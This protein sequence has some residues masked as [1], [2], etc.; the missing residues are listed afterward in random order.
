MQAVVDSIKK[1]IKDNIGRRV[2][3]T[4]KEGRNRFVVCRGV[5]EESYPNVF[6][7]KYENPQAT[8]KEISR[9]SYSYIDVLTHNVQVSLY[10]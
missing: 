1:S 10:K 2:K 4:S 7:V 6:V 9:I 8:N 5:I 3:V